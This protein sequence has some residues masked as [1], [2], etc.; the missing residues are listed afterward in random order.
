[1]N[2]FPWFKNYPA[3]I[4]H[5]LGALEFSSL[6]ELFENAC[7]KYGSR[8]AFENLGGKIRT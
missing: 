2:D 4:P 8:I 7:K 5:E 6:P 1:M 3:G